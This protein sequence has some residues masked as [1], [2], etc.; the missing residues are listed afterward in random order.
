M[1][2][3]NMLYHFLFRTEVLVTNIAV[4]ANK[5]VVKYGLVL[6]VGYKVFMTD[7]TF[8]VIVMRKFQFFRQDQDKLT[9]VTFLH[10]YA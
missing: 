4:N 6:R 3:L 8:S 9:L 1:N 5:V 10:K 2:Y 7:F